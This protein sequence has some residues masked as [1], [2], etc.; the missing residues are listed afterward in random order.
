MFNLP[1]SDIHLAAAA[2]DKKNAIEQVAKALENAG[3]AKSG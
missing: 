2:S 1:I 3:Y